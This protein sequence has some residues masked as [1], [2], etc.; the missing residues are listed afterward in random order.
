MG[1][2]THNRIYVCISA[3]PCLVIVDLVI[4]GSIGSSHHHA[5]ILFLKGC[6]SPLAS[7]CATVVAAARRRRRR[8]TSSAWAT[9]PA[10][11]DAALGR[12]LAG[13]RRRLARALP[14]L[15]AAPASGRPCGLATSGS[16]LRAGCNRLCLRGYYTCGWL[17]LAGG[18][19]AAGRPLALGP[20]LQSTAPLQVVDR[21]CKGTG[22]GH[23]RLPLARASFAAKMQQEC[24]ERFYAIQSHHTQFKTNLSHENL[25]SDTTVGKPIAGA[26]HA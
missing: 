13:R 24:V 19:V 23:A 1:L 7:L 8:C 10:A 17:P 21:R 18:M 16:P 26:S 14:L 5:I 15:A 22:R 9:A 2:I 20:W 12:D 6:P 3:S 25:G 4:I 11:S